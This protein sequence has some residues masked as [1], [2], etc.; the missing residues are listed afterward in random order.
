MTLFHPRFFASLA[1]RIA[2]VGVGGR[3][4]IPIAPAGNGV[5]EGITL[6]VGE[7]LSLYVVRN[8][9]NR[10]RASLPQ[11][12]RFT[13]DWLVLG[14]AGTVLAADTVLISAADPAWV[15]TATGAGEADM[16]FFLG[17]LAPANNP[18]RPAPL[19]RLRQGAQLG[20]RQGF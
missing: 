1:R 16:G 11:A 10:L 17:P 18:L 20:V 13:A 5:S 12:S 9:P 7:P 8:D 14:A 15:F 6:A 19:R 3:I 2:A 4:W